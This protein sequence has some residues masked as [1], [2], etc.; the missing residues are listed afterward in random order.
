MPRAI[1]AF[2]ATSKTTGPWEMVLRMTRQPL[3]GPPQMV[4]VV[5]NCA[6]LPP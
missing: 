4:L 3:I 2:I 6:D 5:V 1:T